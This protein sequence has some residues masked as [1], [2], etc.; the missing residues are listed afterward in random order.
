MSNMSWNSNKKNPQKEK[1]KNFKLNE[2]VVISILTDLK[3]K[4]V[5]AINLNPEHKRDFNTQKSY[6]TE[7]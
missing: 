2:Y 4:A 6:M 5:L 1:I 3:N 7:I